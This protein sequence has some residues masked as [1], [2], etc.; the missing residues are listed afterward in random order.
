MPEKICSP[1]NTARVKIINLSNKMIVKRIDTILPLAALLAAA[2]VSC[3]KTE[4]EEPR[5]PV[6][7][8]G[9]AVTLVA[10]GDTDNDTRTELRDVRTNWWTVG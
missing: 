9:F 8:E 6:T 2:L 1:S 5:I 7:E 4:T 10:S 3:S